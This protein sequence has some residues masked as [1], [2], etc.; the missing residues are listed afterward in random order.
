MPE[1]LVEA[2]DVRVHVGR[3]RLGRGP[4]GDVQVEPG[5]HQEQR[6]ETRKS[7]TFVHNTPQNTSLRPS[8]SCHR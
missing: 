6:E 2:L 5:E 7:A 3:E 4:V 8:E 1:H